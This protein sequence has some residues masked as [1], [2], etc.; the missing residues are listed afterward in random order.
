M[1]KAIIPVTAD[2]WCRLTERS[3]RRVIGKEMRQKS[4]RPGQAME[5]RGP[6]GG[7]RGETLTILLGGWVEVG[8]PTSL[9]AGMGQLPK[10]VSARTGQLSCL[11]E[12]PLSTAGHWSLYQKNNGYRINSNYAAESI[13][14]YST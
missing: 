4:G 7:K 8:S 3:E 12:K 9:A 13:P 1:F 5:S 11:A 2:L 14:L 10:D 6:R